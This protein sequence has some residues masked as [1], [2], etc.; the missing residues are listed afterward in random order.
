VHFFIQA[1]LHFTS[2]KIINSTHFRQCAIFPRPSIGHGLKRISI[3][4]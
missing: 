3:D 4:E 1:S 2:S